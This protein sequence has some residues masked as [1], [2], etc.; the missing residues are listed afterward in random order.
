MVGWQ[1]LQVPFW[2]KMTF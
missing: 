1:K 2:A